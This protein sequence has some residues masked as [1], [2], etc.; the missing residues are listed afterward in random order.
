MALFGQ[1][2]NILTIILVDVIANVCT[3]SMFD[4]YLN[5]PR[6]ESNPNMRDDEYLK[7]PPLIFCS[8]IIM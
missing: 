7:C 5:G 4:E 6:H 3:A 1:T 8:S 2:D